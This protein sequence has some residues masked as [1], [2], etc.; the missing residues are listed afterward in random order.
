MHY[1]MLVVTLVAVFSGAV[2]AQ[3]PQK[4]RYSVV[5][6]DTGDVTHFR[7]EEL[8]WQ[9]QQSSDRVI[10]VGPRHFWKH[11]RSV[12]FVFSRVTDQIGT[13]HPVSGL[14]WS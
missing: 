5:F 13:P 6:S 1:S 8:P 11:R 2:S 10:Q 4:L 9:V 7:D 12:F 3:Q 14:S